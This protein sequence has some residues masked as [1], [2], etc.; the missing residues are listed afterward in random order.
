MKGRLYHYHQCE[1]DLVTFV[2]LMQMSVLNVMKLPFVVRMAKR[3]ARNWAVNAELFH[4][5]FHPCACSID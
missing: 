2:R 5:F 3:Q 4:S 1:E